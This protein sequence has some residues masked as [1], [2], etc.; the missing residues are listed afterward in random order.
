MKKFFTTAWVVIVAAV[1]VTAG[2]AD[3]LKKS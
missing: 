2:G 3:A 1:A